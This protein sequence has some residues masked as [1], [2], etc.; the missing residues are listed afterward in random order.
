MP[1]AEATPGGAKDAAGSPPAAPLAR[2][3]PGDRRQWIG[4]ILT[5]RNQNTLPWSWIA[6]CPVLA[7]P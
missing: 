3:R 4:R 2:R 1:V 6:M 7:S 5:L